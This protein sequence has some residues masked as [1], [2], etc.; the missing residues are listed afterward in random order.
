MTPAWG[1]ER[2]EQEEPQLAI[3][4]FAGDVDLEQALSVEYGLEA[5]SGWDD[6]LRHLES[7]RE[8]ARTRAGL[9]R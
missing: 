6:I 4:A 1:S 8:R 5:N 9:G 3:Y 2:L 7:E